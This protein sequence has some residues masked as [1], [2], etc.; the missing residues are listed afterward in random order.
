MVDVKDCPLPKLQKMI[1]AATTRITL[2][3]RNAK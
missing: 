2:K 3:N 1:V